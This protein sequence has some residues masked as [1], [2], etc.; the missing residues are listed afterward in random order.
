MNKIKKSMPVQAKGKR[1][2]FLTAP[3][4]DKAI[5]IITGLVGEV[6]VLHDELDTLR[7]V[8]IEK[9]IIDSESLQAYQQND[10]TRQERE[11]WRELF[12]E[13]VFRV[14]EQDVSSM[15][16]KQKDNH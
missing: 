12:L 5:S 2:Q 14:V 16:D 8:L 7:K 15:E 3:G 6:S 10:Q 9:K 13:N 11:N 1:P 4:L